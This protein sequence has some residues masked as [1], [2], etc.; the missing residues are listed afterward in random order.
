[1][2][3]YKLIIYLSAVLSHI[4]PSHPPILY[5]KQS[6]I[7]ALWKARSSCMGARVDQVLV[8]KSSFSAVF[9]K[10]SSVSF[11]PPVHNQSIQTNAHIFICRKFYAYKNQLP[12]PPN[13][14][15]SPLNPA[16]DKWALWVFI[17]VDSC[18]QSSFSS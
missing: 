6:I 10:L 4:F 12:I 8:S 17:G 7:A 16:T 1:M 2:Y 14:N 5:T 11:L 13:A 9:K 18:Q 15:N 3:I